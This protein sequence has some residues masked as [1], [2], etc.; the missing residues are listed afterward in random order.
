MARAARFRTK[1]QKRGANVRDPQVGDGVAGPSAAIEEEQGFFDRVPNL[2]SKAPQAIQDSVA[3]LIAQKHAIRNVVGADTPNKVTQSIHENR[4]KSLAFI[5]VGSTALGGGFAGES[6]KIGTAS[7]ASS[8][9]GVD[10][11]QYKDLMSPAQVTKAIN[12]PTGNNNQT[13]VRA[14]FIAV[15]NA[16]PSMK[17]RTHQPGSLY[18]EKDGYYRARLKDSRKSGTYVFE[19]DYTGR[20]TPKDVKSIQV[21]EV[22]KIFSGVFWKSHAQYAPI[23]YGFT[24]ASGDYEN[25]GPK[26]AGW[27]ASVGYGQKKNAAGSFS[28]ASALA[29]G[30]HFN[31]LLSLTPNVLTGIDSQFISVAGK[32]K[33]HKPIAYQSILPILTNERTCQA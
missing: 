13:L 14:A 33:K 25:R 6:L 15:R 18:K 22:P 5:A 26:W 2:G 3:W 12:E 30:E 20:F 21:T 32:A 23:W 9:G 10:C 1:R 27:S 29:N 16:K 8:S 24:I 7:A 4:R 11:V 31:N 19:V 28:L 17:Y